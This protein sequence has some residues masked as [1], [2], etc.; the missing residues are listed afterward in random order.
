MAVWGATAAG[1]FFGYTPPPRHTQLDH[2]SFW[3]KLGKLDLPGLSILTAGLTLLLVGLNLGGELFPWSNARVLAT[4]IVGI[5]LLF[6]FGI[7]EWKGTSTGVIHHE[8]FMP[9]GQ[10]RTFAICVLLIF[11]EGVLLFTY[12]IFYPAL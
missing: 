8:L 2:L 1:I 6:F 7:Y 4:L 10:G 3:Q 12:I 9:G 11:L 5:A